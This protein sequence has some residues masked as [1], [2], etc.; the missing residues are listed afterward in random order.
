MPAKSGFSQEL[1]RRPGEKLAPLEA[2]VSL[3]FEDGLPRGGVHRVKPRLV[4]QIGFSEWRREASC[5]TLDSTAC[6]MTSGRKMSLAKAD[7]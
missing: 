6:G 1:L 5:D 2:P 3:F 4:A 7:V